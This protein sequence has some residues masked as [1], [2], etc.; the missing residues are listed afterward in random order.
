[1]AD[2][3]KIGVSY[4]A[5]T[6]WESGLYLCFLR[7]IDDTKKTRPFGAPETEPPSVPQFGFEFV[8]MEEYAAPDEDQKYIGA[9]TNVRYGNEK[10]SLTKMVDGMEGKGRALTEEEVKDL[11]L[12]GY[13]GKWWA[14]VVITA[15]DSSG[16][17]LSKVQG[18]RPL[19]T[20]EK[21]EVQTFLSTLSG[22][23]PDDTIDLETGAT[24]SVSS[25]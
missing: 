12:G 1:M 11:D 25:E 2:R 24:E 10:A 9:Y 6:V 21:K 7:T 15:N 19:N 20:K 17:P 23:G 13:I 18:V 8:P 22:L 5:R 14:V 3:K 16:K 4:S